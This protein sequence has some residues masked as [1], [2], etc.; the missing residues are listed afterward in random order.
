MD[1]MTRPKVVYWAEGINHKGRPE[2]AVIDIDAT[3]RLVP[4]IVEQCRTEPQASFW[5]K[6]DADWR[7]LKADVK[8]HL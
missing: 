1:D 4:V 2:D 5:Q 6:M 8:R 3:N 7:K